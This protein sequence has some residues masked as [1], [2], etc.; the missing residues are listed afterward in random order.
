MIEHSKL[1]LDTHIIIW[2]TSG[3]H[4]SKKEVTT[5]EKFRKAKQLYISHISIWEI[6]ML[7]QK[8]KITLAEP[9]WFK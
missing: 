8:G 2:Y 3:I 4:L 5:I 7:V 9:Q 6:C 1:T